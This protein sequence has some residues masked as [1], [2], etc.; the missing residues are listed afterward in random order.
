MLCPAC[1]AYNRANAPLCSRCGRFLPA[2]EPLVLRD[3]DLPYG[4]EDELFAPAAASFGRLHEAFRLETLDSWLT[5]RGR[6]DLAEAAHLLRQAYA[7]SAPACEHFLAIAGAARRAR[8]PETMLESLRAFHRIER[9]RHK[10]IP[11]PA[12]RLEA[13]G[14]IEAA[15]APRRALG[16]AADA[17]GNL[18]A[19]CR[20]ED[21]R[22]E[23]LKFNRAGRRVWRV[24]CAFA[25]TFI[26][27]DERGWLYLATKDGHI[28]RYQG[29][30]SGWHTW[31]LG[32]A[33][34][35]RGLAL[36]GGGVLSVCEVDRHCVHRVRLLER[37]TETLGTLGYGE[38]GPRSLYGAFE[39]GPLGPLASGRG[40]ELYVLEAPNARVQ[41]FA[42]DGHFLRA[43]HLLD[44]AGDPVDATTFALL[45]DGTLLVGRT[46][47]SQL[48]AYAAGGQLCQY[49]DLAFPPHFVHAAGGRVYVSDMYVV[50]VFGLSAV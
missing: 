26:A 20:R 48:L 47:P 7:S 2:V 29:L 8:L 37:G 17:R 1:D 12:Y 34:I 10:P 11:T 22:G 45:D 9:P 21:G 13:Q 23:I 40:D 27:R 42:P 39:F 25:P 4:D 18:W 31:R 41:V 6:S 5:R 43:V 50:R 44:G 49:W 16:M 3:E 32:Q 28:A 30:W 35:L 46:G 15:V 19:A 33:G 24:A 14:E 36:H 38:T